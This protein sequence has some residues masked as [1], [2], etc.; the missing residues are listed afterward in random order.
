MVI[1]ENL[2]AMNFRFDI[3]DYHF[4]FNMTTMQNIRGV[5]KASREQF[6]HNGPPFKFSFSK[7]LS[8]IIFAIYHFGVDNLYQGAV[9]DSVLQFRNRIVG[10]Q[11]TLCKR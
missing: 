2:K 5:S 3:A 11:V 6:Y 8:G 10:P 4:L 9:L 7:K 1:Y